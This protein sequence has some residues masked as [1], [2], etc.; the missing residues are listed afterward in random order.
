M[1]LKASQLVALALIGP[2]SLWAADEAKRSRIVGI[3]QVSLLAQD[4]EKSRAFYQEFLGF[5]EAFT[6]KGTDGAL[7]SAWIKI[8]D[9]QTIELLP[10]QDSGT[11]RLNHVSLEVDDAAAMRLYLAARHV[12][13]PGTTTRGKNGNLHFTVRDPDD[14]LVEF[15]QYA[16]EGGTRRE[17]G[18]FLP[19]TRISA[20]IPHLG[21]LVGDLQKA[22]A[23]YR[24]VL[25]GAE[26]WRG[27]ANPNVLSWVNVKLPEGDD[28][29]EFILY[30]TLPAPNKRRGT[31]HLCLEVPDIEKTRATL[32]E[33]AARIGYTR[34]ME[35]KTGI[36][37]RRQINLFDPDGTRVEVME[38]NTVDGVPVPSSTA[39]PP[40]AGKST[41]VDARD[42]TDT[43][44]AK[45]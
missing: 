34:E 18:K 10:E 35:I 41:K 33:R 14:H 19:T 9:R 5:E 11:D 26:T 39:P 40:N 32:L 29:L 27:G 3:A 43:S 37:R 38:P 16:A 45:K 36:N 6:V 12:K 1:H 23:F 7:R 21:I 8:N 15:V 4:L 31:H 42:A 28:Y 20:R 22:L 24:G 2:L 44:K 17:Q 30:Q 13:V 25:G